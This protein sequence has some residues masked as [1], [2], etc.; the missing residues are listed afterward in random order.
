M[1]TPL[2]PGWTWAAVTI[3]LM[4]GSGIAGYRLA[5]SSMAADVAQAEQRRMQCEQTRA[6]EAMAAAQKNAALLA[7]AQD[8]EA[9]AASRMAAARAAHEKNLQETRREIY[10]L[11]ADRECLS[12]AVRLRLNAAIAAS[13]GLPA[14]A[15]AADPEHAEPAADSGER[16]ATDAD[17]AGW[18]LDAARQYDECRARIDAIRHWDEVTHGR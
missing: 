9:Q 8:A 3:G 17:I 18:A 13:D 12:A 6:E 11:T 5:E 10:R 1:I 4:A 7:R 16:I 2:M 15:A 14:R